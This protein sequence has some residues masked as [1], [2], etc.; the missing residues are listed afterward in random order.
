MLDPGHTVGAIPAKPAVLDSVY[1]TNAD[2]LCQL[3]S[4]VRH[5]MTTKEFLAIARKEDYTIKTL[6]D[7]ET[8]DTYIVKLTDFEMNPPTTLAWV[9]GQESDHFISYEGLDKK[10][11]YRALRALAET[12]PKE[13]EDK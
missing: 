9:C 10:E 8:G 13:R 3:L 5:N 2:K 1:R 7:P 12:P 4:N 11:S 6:L